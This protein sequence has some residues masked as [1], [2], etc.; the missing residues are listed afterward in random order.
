MVVV[1]SRKVQNQVAHLIESVKLTTN[2]DYV[3][4][5]KK[6]RVIH[7]GSPLSRIN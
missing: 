1:K 5:N 6:R 7:S 2:K 4:T 3:H